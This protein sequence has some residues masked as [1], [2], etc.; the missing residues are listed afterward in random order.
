MDSL[1][2]LYKEYFVARTKKNA[3]LLHPIDTVVHWYEEVQTIP[4]QLKKNFEAEKAK[5]HQNIKI[6]TGELKKARVLHQK[7]K[8][9]KTQAVRKAKKLSSPIAATLLEKA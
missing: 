3:A 8:T 4:A 9:L 2:F 1:F 6:L 7:A 5:A